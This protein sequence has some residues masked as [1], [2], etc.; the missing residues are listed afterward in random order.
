MVVV[1]AE[2]AVVEAA[3]VAEGAEALACTAVD[4]LTRPDVRERAW[5]LLR[6]KAAAGR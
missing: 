6:A 4:V 2:A 3:V 5:E 1:A